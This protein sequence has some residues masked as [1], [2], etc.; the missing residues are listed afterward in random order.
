[1]PCDVLPLT[2]SLFL[3][4]PLPTMTDTDKVRVLIGDNPSDVSQRTFT[5]DD[6]GTFLDVEQGDLLLAAALALDA[7]AAKADI[8]PHQVSIGKFQYSAGR[9]QIRQL[10][11]Q[12]EGFRQRA[13]NS[14]AFAVIQD[15]LSSV[16]ALVMLRNQILRNF[17]AIDFDIS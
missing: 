4:S 16:N 5:D 9:T 14:P 2:S 17:G 7:M 11:Q 10:T 6:L 13:Y 8:T 12:A 3:A 15:N 1:M